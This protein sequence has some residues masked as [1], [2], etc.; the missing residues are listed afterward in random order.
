ML[1]HCRSIDPFEVDRLADL[2][3]EG[4]LVFKAE[5]IRRRGI[6]SVLGE[7]A[8]KWGGEDK[9]KGAVWSFIHRAS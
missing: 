9:D 7:I 4:G 3:R 6:E 5:D 2:E 1:I 8:M